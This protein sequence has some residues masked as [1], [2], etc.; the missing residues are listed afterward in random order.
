LLSPEDSQKV[1]LTSGQGTIQFVLRGG[2]DQKNVDVRPT[3]LA[4]LLPSEAPPAP[5]APPGKKTSK[6]APPAK[7]P[8]VYVLEVI[9]GTQ[10]KV[11]KF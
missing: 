10:R 1:L 5:A 9:Q 7:P 3:R 11:E 4:Q 8:T 6:R 2:A